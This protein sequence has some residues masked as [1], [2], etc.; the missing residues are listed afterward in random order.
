MWAK[1]TA[2]FLEEFLWSE[3]KMWSY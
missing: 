2:I 1:S 3:E